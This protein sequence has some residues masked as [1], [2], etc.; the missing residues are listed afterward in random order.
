MQAQLNTHQWLE[1]PMATR[2]R[3][4][5]IF[6]IPRSSGT[7]VEDGRVASDGHTHRDLESISVLAM[8]AL[9]DTD[10]VDFYEL[11]DMVIKSIEPVP[12]PEP[13]QGTVDNYVENVPKSIFINNEEYMLVKKSEHIGMHKIDTTKTI[14]SKPKAAAK[15]TVAKRTRGVKK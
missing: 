10:V 5:Q 11:F 13:T 9:L 6:H 14:T 15:K 1:L 4:V 2:Q 3:L 7:V 8:Q 12:E